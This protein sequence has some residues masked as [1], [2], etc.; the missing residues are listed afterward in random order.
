MQACP[1]LVNDHVDR[2]SWIFA[3]ADGPDGR[4]YVVGGYFERRRP[5][6][7]GLLRFERDD[8]GV[9]FKLAGDQCALIGPAAESFM[10]LDDDGPAAPILASLAADLR[11]RLGQG[12]HDD[13][14]VIRAVHRGSGNLLKK[15]AAL[16]AAFG[17]P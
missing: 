5:V 4:Y 3:Q 2:H 8:R 10:A 11:R 9:M 12:V 17:G 15:S 14:Q 16:Q 6:P 7:K 13:R 1:A